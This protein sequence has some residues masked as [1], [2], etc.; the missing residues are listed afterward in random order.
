MASHDYTGV[1]VTTRAFLEALEASDRPQLSELPVDEAKI[2]FANAEMAGAPDKLPAE[3]EDRMVPGGPQGNVAVRI[4]RPTGNAEMLPVVMFLHGGGW[5]FGDK[6]THDRLIREIATGAKAA[7]VFVEF[8]R[9]PEARYPV[10]VEEAYAGTKW[11]AEH[12][13]SIDLDSSRLALFGD[14]AG[15]NMAA[16]VTL[17]ARQRG[18]PE[19]GFQ[20]LFYPVTDAS[21]DT[22]SYRAYQ[23][24]YMLTREGMR[25]SWNQYA[26]DEGTQKKP[27]ASPLRASLARLQGLPPT[28]IIN[29]EFDVLRDEGEAYAHRLIEA[30]VPVTATRYLGTIHA[31]VNLGAL[32][33]TPAARAVAAP[34]PIAPNS[35]TPTTSAAFSTTRKTGRAIRRHAILSRQIRGEHYANRSS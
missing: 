24:G 7:V 32:A 8:A 1:E 18:G 15:G 27:T 31:F 28:L 4:V 21:L 6:N 33:G 9:P 35:T 3:I 20:V 30:G 11:V 16:A 12:G 13:K 34:L 25:W 22:A 23:E 5:V 17:V 10:A 14:S 2:A 29:A 19:I 26:P